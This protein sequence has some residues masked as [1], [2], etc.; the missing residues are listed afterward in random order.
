MAESLQILFKTYQHEAFLLQS[1]HTVAHKP[2]LSIT[3]YS[4]RKMVHAQP[5]TKMNS[6][7]LNLVIFTAIKL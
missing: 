4:M 7:P 2:N 5:L 6:D 1:K 3:Y